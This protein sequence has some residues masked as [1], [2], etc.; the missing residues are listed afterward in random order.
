MTSLP[1]LRVVPLLALLLLSR[2]SHAAFDFAQVVQRADRLAAAGW[3][4]PPTTVPDWLLGISYDQWRDIRFRPNRTL[5]RDGK[6][7]FQVQLF[8]PGLFYNRPVAVNV[9]DAAGKVAPLAFSPSYFD[10]G[11]NDFASRIPQDLGWAGVR[12]HGPIKSKNYFDEVIVFLGATYFRSLGRDQGFGLSARGLA[13]DTA[14]SW[15]EEFPW[16]REFWLMT[17]TPNAT[18]VT[19]FAL[20]DSPRITGAYQ[21][22]V[23]PGVETTVKVECRLFL[24]KNIEKIGIAPLTSMF[25]HGENSTRWVSDFR[26]EVHDSDGLLLNF[27]TG[28]WLWRP[29]DNPRTLSVS[30]LGM[31]SPKGFGLIQR[32]RSFE[33]YQD[34]ETQAER[35]PSAWVEPTG[36]WGPGRIEL[37]EIPTNDDSNDNVV[38]YWVPANQPKPGVPASFAYVIHWYGDDPDMP[39]GG[40][41][42]ATRHDTR[43]VPEG[44]H[45]FV[46]DF[47]SKQLNELPADQVVRGVVTVAGGEDAGQITEQ[48]VVKNPHAGGW[49]LT[50]H[51]RPRKKDPLELRAYLDHDNTVL[52]ETWSHAL[53]P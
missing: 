30:S 20:L 12:L 24:R 34:L 9:V 49:R 29:V 37:I 42:L 22:V 4:G 5:W 35:R 46:I 36:D 40:R 7:P 2:P 15:G 3:G 11:K 25:F 45:R 19:L 38:A 14:E 53:R 52:T 18:D 21:F 17:P 51:V 47:A 28:E 31:D 50:F 8:H 44:E 43:N 1:R 33:S 6:L 23:R 16:F 48:H 13:V 41:V 39:P 27:R 32:D 10:Y 26:P